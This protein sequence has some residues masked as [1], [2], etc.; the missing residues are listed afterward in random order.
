MAPRKPLSDRMSPSSPK[1][2]TGKGKKGKGK[3]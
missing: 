3:C 2:K 1:P